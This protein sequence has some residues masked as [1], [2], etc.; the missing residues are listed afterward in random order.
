MNGGRIPKLVL[1]VSLL[2]LLSVFTLGLF[3]LAPVMAAESGGAGWACDICWPSACGGCCI[4]GADVTPEPD[5][6]HV[7]CSECGCWGYF[8]GEPFGYTMEPCP[9]VI[10]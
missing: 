1:L 7:G 5:C 2:L 10:Q 4:N 8:G 6:W 9:N 3:R